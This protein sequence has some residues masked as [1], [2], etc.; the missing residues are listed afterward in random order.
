MVTYRLTVDTEIVYTVSTMVNDST[1]DAMIRANLARLSQLND[2]EVSLTR[3]VEAA[4]NRVANLRA[5]RDA[6][7]QFL[8]RELS[9]PGLEW[10]FQN[11]QQIFEPGVNTSKVNGNTE[12]SASTVE[13]KNKTH[14]MLA[15]LKASPKGLL[16]AGIV[17]AAKEHFETQISAAYTYSTLGKLIKRGLVKK[18][19]KGLYTLTEKGKGFELDL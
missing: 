2:E 9:E 11:L 19:D 13:S 17:N 8:Q 4:T 18:G 15:V 14:V 1:H 7:R 16:P 12:D 6:L 10:A 5:K 3:E